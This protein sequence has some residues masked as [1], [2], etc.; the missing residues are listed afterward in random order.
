MRVLEP[1]A[2]QLAQL[3]QQPS[4]QQAIDDHRIVFMSSAELEELAE[5]RREKEDAAASE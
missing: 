5:F 1:R 2:V 3:L 4:A